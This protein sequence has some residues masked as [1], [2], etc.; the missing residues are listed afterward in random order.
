[1]PSIIEQGNVPTP[2]VI[3]D[4]GKSGAGK[5]SLPLRAKN[6]FGEIYVLDAEHQAQHATGDAY[7]K[8]VSDQI[9]TAA[10]A[11]MHIANLAR[12]DKAYALNGNMPRVL[13]I[14][15]VTVLKD[16][17]EN[18]VY[19]KYANGD[20]IVMFDTGKWAQAKRP[21]RFLLNEIQRSSGKFDVVY[22][23]AR[24]KAEMVGSGNDAKYTGN[25]IPDLP[26]GS[27]YSANMI[28]EVKPDHTVTIKKSKPSLEQW[29]KDGQAMTFEKFYDGLEGALQKRGPVVDLSGMTTTQIEFVTEAMNGE[30]TLVALDNIAFKYH[31]LVNGV[32]T[33]GDKD[34]VHGV[35]KASNFTNPPAVAKDYPGAVMAVAKAIVIPAETP[36]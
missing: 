26:K 24:A 9:D 6:R 36:A 2:I 12:G 32:S 27:D 34:I 23:V 14:D 18:R 4:Y 13:V 31:Y 35:L 25:D 15:T 33:K 7:P 11:E 8:F 10:Q 3:L 17:A 1:M 29:F 21:I 20:N 28:V 16:E 22:I 30:R 19:D 5:T